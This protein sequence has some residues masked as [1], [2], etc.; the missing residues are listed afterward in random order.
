MV[1][2]PF[3]TE[4]TEDTELTEVFLVFEFSTG[5]LPVEAATYE[6]L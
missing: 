5:R 6:T 3:I 1:V 4:I 2:F